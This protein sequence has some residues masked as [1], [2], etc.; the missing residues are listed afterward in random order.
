[1]KIKFTEPKVFTFVKKHKV[2]FTTVVELAGFAGTVYLAC[3][4]KTK[5]DQIIAQ[6]EAKKE[7]PLTTKEKAKIYAKTTWIAA[8]LGTA[9]TALIIYSNY[10]FGSTIKELGTATL[11]YKQHLADRKQAEIDK[12]GEK[13]A[14]N[15]EA[16]ANRRAAN[17]LYSDKNVV[18]TGRGPTLFY[19]PYTGYFI[20]DDIDTVNRAAVDFANKANGKNGIDL[21]TFFEI[22]GWP[23]QNS[24]I[25]RN[26]IFARNSEA[27]ALP[28]LKWPK[29]D[30]EVITLDSGEVATVLH[31]TYEPEY[32]DERAMG[33]LD[34]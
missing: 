8:A 16:E 21:A 11:L 27:D 5:A 19:E 10:Q 20:R 6:E 32:W 33:Y 28:S 18:D 14:S 17:R 26:M 23:C 30:P 24:S 7:E 12:Y 29:Y 1:M 22:L 34:D 31:W 4:E 9:E 25:A 3:T 2:F 13:K 15:I